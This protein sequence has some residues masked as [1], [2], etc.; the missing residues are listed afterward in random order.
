MLMKM[1]ENSYFTFATAVAVNCTQVGIGPDATPEQSAK[2]VEEVLNVIFTN[3]GVTANVQPMQYPTSS[4]IPLII[5]LNGSVQR[6][7]WFYPQMS[8]CE[9]ADEFAELFSD[10]NM[11]MLFE[12]A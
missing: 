9:L 11:G 7:L 6:L 1:K 8:S 5:T 3:S 10:V 4:K 12:S 2:F